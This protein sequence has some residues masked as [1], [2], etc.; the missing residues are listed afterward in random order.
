[1][2]FV[3]RALVVYGFLLLLLRAVGKRQ[4]ASITVFDF[5][6]ILII[7]E[8]TQSSL[9][10]TEDRSVTTGLVVVGTLVAA[11]LALSFVKRVS[12]RAD[13]IL[14]GRP[15]LLVEHGRTL[16]EVMRKERVDEEDILASARRTQG[17]ER[18]EQVKYAVLERDGTITVVP[19]R[20]PGA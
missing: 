12:R 17:L 9:L 6:L 4:L 1:M 15:V 13:A 10:D 18:L 14:E 16:E 2:E 20:G 5:V 7:A 3:L 11:D 8:A 19:E